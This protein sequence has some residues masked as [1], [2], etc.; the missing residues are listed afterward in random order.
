MTSNKKTALSLGL[1]LILV[2]AALW[3]V[4]QL[5]SPE[6]SRERITSIT[7]IGELQTEL[8][9]ERL[10]GR[11]TV[12]RE[13]LKENALRLVDDTRGPVFLDPARCL[14]MRVQDKDWRGPKLF[15]WIAYPANRR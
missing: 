1:N 12:L 10:L 9:A 15:R 14:W 11:I 6:Q 8:A 3:L 13:E 5:L 7:R 2:G 4:M